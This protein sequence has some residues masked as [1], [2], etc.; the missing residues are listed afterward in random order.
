[1]SFGLLND[2]I[3][4]SNE[5]RIE[6]LYRYLVKGE[7]GTYIAENYY[8]NKNYAWKISAI[9]QGYCEKGGKNRGKVSATIDEIKLFVETYFEGTYQSGITLTDWLVDSSEQKSPDDGVDKNN[10]LLK[11]KFKINFNDVSYA[12]RTSDTFNAGSDHTFMRYENFCEALNQ[13]EHEIAP[14]LEY[15]VYITIHNS[16]V[17][18][19]PYF[20]ISPAD[21]DYTKLFNELSDSDIHF[22]KCQ[23]FDVWEMIEYFGKVEDFN[24]AED[25]N[26]NDIFK[27]VY[28]TFQRIY[29]SILKTFIID[30]EIDKNRSLHFLN[31]IVANKLNIE[32]LE[33][34]VSNKFYFFDSKP[35]EKWINGLIEHLKHASDFQVTAQMATYYLYLYNWPLKTL[36]YILKVLDGFHLNEDFSYALLNYDLIEFKN[37][38]SEIERWISYRLSRIE[39]E[40]L[41]SIV[42]GNK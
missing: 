6:V 10:R 14:I 29:L 37:N 5:E 3:Q 4:T 26:Q 40:E 20:Y 17:E 35:D 31:K 41:F 33:Y 16:S 32:V 22:I 15:F 19:L 1:M 42:S 21:L 36:P 39:I 2:F 18:W 30:F 25:W 27:N 13:N 38:L 12:V 23:L 8:N 7:S 34:L 28:S 9:T 24:N 11:E